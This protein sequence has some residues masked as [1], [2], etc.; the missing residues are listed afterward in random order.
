[1]NVFNAICGDLIFKCIECM[2]FVTG[3][4]LKAKSSCISSWLKN[5]LFFFFKKIS[6][7]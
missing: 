7:F 2:L 3:L 6:C 4:Y 1:M 5:K